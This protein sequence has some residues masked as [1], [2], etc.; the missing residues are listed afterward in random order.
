MRVFFV[1]V[2]EK[3][4]LFQTPNNKS[5]AICSVPFSISGNCSLAKN[6]KNGRHGLESYTGEREDVKILLCVTQTEKTKGG[7]FSQE[8]HK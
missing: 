8:I 4:L 3:Y 5:L 7:D 1:L 2:L 6:G